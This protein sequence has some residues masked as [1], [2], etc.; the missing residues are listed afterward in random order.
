[1][2]AK[3]FPNTNHIHRRKFSIYSNLFQPV[4]DTLRVACTLSHG[5]TGPSLCESDLRCG[6]PISSST[7]AK[8]KSESQTES[9][10]KQ[11]GEIS[12]QS[13]FVC[14]SCGDILYCVFAH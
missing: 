1:M 5:I 12:V 14:A 9:L 4:G 13:L 6:F 10:S 2:K 3:G 11:G 8:L 7:G